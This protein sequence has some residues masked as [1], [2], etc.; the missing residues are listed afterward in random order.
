MNFPTIPPRPLFDLL[1]AR[2]PISVAAEE[3]ARLRAAGCEIIESPPGRFRLVQAS[4]NVW[5]DHLAELTIHRFPQRLVEIY[6][7]TSSTQNVIRRLIEAKGAAADGAIAA[8]DEQTAGRGRLGRK[9][10][11]L[12]GWSVLFSRA[13]IAKPGTSPTPE[14]LAM[15]AAVAVANGIKGVLAQND[16]DQRAAARVGIKWPNDILINEKKVAG[17]LVESLPQSRAAIIGIGINVSHDASLIP[18][19]VRHRFGSLDMFGCRCDRLLVLSNV[20]GALDIWLAPD[21]NRQDALEAWRDMNIYGP[22]EVV[23]FQQNGQIVRGNILDL[24]ASAGLVVRTEEGA[25][26][27][28]PAATTSVV[29]ETK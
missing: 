12:P 2:R 1:H 8:T 17:I 26:V 7:Q 14:W 3:I 18:E 5:S 11:A 25:I 13:Y 9:W 20:V 15:A 6:K 19:Q 21:V 27:H 10:H 23:T 29:I 22:D 28:L 16:V 4:L 24:D